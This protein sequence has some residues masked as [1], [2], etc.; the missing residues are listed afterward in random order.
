MNT[1]RIILLVFFSA[2]I[3]S[4]CEKTLLL[5]EENTSVTEDGNLTISIS[6]LE[7]TPFSTLTRAVPSEVCTHL[8]FAIYNMDGTR[9]KQDNQKLGD[10]DYGTVSFLLTEGNYQLVVLAHSSDGNPTMTN[11]SKIQFTNALGYTDT[12]HYYTQITI[13]NEPQTLSLTLKRIVSLCRFVISDAIPE[14]IARLEFEYTGGSGHFD[15]KTG[16]GVTKST[17]KVKYDV[18]SG[19]TN[20]QYDLYSFLHESTGTI[21]LK[22]KAYD[23]NDNVQHERQFDIPMIQNQ[24]TWFSG[25]FFTGVTPTTSQSFTSTISINTTWGGEQHLTY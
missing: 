20:T 7:Q 9:L 2:V 3:L 14:G 17:Q 19:Q 10:T 25:D 12:F 6:Q 4:G 8:N 16:L 15:A 22:V 24:I 23:A 5:D 11:P 13:S 1:L 21:H 18:L